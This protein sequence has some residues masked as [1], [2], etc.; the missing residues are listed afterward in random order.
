MKE[1]DNLIIGGGLAGGYAAI[2]LR[3]YDK[4][5]SIAIVTDEKHIP[6]DRVPLSKEYLQ[7]KVKQESLFIRKHD[8]YIKNNIEIINNKRVVELDLNN[9]IAFLDDNSEIKF[10]K[11]LLATGGYPRKLKMGEEDKQN[12]FYLRRIEHSD[13]IRETAFN[14]KKAVIIGGGFI[15]CEIASSLKKLGV[16]STIIEKANSILT[17]ALDEETA[18]II[19]QHFKRSGINVITGTSVKQFIAKDNKVIGVETESGEEIMADMFVVGIGIKV[20]TELAEKAGL[21]VNNG[22]VVN[23]RL[24]TRKENVFA[25]GDVASFYHPLY[26]TYMRVEHYD[27]AVKHGKI[28]GSNMAGINSTFNELPYFFSYMYNLNIYSWGM[29][30]GY[31]YIVKRGELDVEKGFL[32]FYFKKGQMIAVL[33]VNTFK[34]ADVARKI[35]A[36]KKTF[37]NPDL[38]ADKNRNLQDFLS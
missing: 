13:K 22:I 8:F 23:E 18:K 16:E 5:T 7:G 31:D 38:L 20:S 21:E 25:A 17:L 27:V 28:A 2:T 19:E 15:G 12:V 10:K 26:E 34:E 29:I 35:I 14:S 24:M 3:Q 9:N 4:N 37:E 32:Q 36:S 6:Y 30:K 33:G 11:V 1:I